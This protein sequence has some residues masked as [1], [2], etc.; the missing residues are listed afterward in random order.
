MIGLRMSSY[1]I[2]V[3][4]FASFNDKDYPKLQLIVDGKLIGSAFVDSNNTETFTFSANL[5]PGQPH[6]VSIANPNHDSSAQLLNVRSIAVNGQVISGTSPLEQYVSSGG[7]IPQWNQMQNGGEMDFRLPASVFPGS[8]TAAP[9][10]P[11][12]ASPTPVATVPAPAPTPAPAPAPTAAA[13]SGSASSASPAV[14]VATSGSNSGDGSLAHPF[15]TLQA[16]VS[17]IEQ[18]GVKQ[19]IVEA[20]TYRPSATLNLGAANNGISITGSGSVVLDGSASGTLMTLKGAS[21]V[22]LSGLGF[23]N[24]GAPAVLIDGGSGNHVAGDSF[25]ADGEAVL[26]QNGAGSNTVSGNTMSGSGGSAIEIKDGSDNNTIDGNVIDGVGAGNTSGGGI[27]LHGASYNQLTHN[28]VENTQGS[29]INLSDFYTTGAGTQNIGN[30]VA[31]NAVENTDQSSTDSGAIYILGRSGAATQTTVKANFISGT[32]SPQQHS[33]GIYLDDNANG[34]SVTGNIVTGIGS[35]G[36]EIHGGSSNSFSGNIFDLGTGAPSAGLFQSAPADQPNS[37]PLQNNAVS[38]NIFVSESTSP[39][40]SLFANYGGGNPSI[41]GND[42]SSTVG[43]S[44]NAAGDT[45]ASYVSPG[46]SSGNWSTQ[47]DG[48]GFVAIDTAKIG[49]H[50]GTV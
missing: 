32:G 21:S 15:A 30:T 45:K 35:D 43:A 14:Y 12:A 34:V 27:Y 37:N 40:N 13:A 26:L 4:A 42:Y 24:A 3:S 41:T 6:T 39:R 1:A 9:A 23:N 47:G 50:S 25:N 49:P 33:V 18:S 28:L 31:Y 38:G 36:F 11:V 29:G 44:L 20:G 46:V 19:L 7:T 5:T 8:A 48:I 17:A 2:T 10:A 22:T 16:A